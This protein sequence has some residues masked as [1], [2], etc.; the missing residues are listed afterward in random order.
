MRQKCARTALTPLKNVVMIG[1]LC[2][3]PLPSCSLYTQHISYSHELLP[4][5]SYVYFK[6][7]CTAVLYIYKYMLLS[8][9]LHLISRY[10][11]ICYKYYVLFVVCCMLPCMSFPCPF[12]DA[13]ARLDI[14]TLADI[15]SHGFS[16]L[17]VYKG[18][19]TN[20]QGILL[21]KNL[22]PI[23]PG[24]KAC[25]AFAVLQNYISAVHNTKTLIIPSYCHTAILPYC[26]AA[27]LQYQNTT[28]PQYYN[29]TRLQLLPLS[30]ILPLL[31]S[32]RTSAW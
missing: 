26:H 14:E 10:F 17:P 21:V 18:E 9:L 15:V 27:A 4:P 23:N 28:V 31:H 32:Q 25:S 2:A 3:C 22:I 13:R 16:R 5:L 20:I 24:S 6:Y 1:E 12:S 8:L 30:P 19:R 11:S 29:F 7:F